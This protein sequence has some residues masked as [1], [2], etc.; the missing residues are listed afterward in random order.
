LRWLLTEF[1]PGQ[2]H[3][4]CSSTVAQGSAVIKTLVFGLME[5]ALFDRL[6]RGP[7]WSLVHYEKWLARSLLHLPADMSRPKRHRRVQRKC[8]VNG[9]CKRSGIP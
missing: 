3:A 1:T 4:V 9:P 5:P 8:D 2:A 7:G 6:A